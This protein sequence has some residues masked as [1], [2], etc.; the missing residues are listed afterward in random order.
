MSNLPQA[1]VVVVSHQRPAALRRCLLA[2][3]LQDHPDYEVIVVADRA[4]LDAI[5]ELP[6]FDRLKTTRQEETGI[7]AARNRGIALAAGQVVAFIDDDSA[8]EPTWL[9]RLSAPFA[10][11]SVDAAGGFV[12]GRNG[13]SYQWRAK[14]FDETGAHHDL[15]CDDPAISLHRGRPGCAIKTEGTNMALRRSVLMALGGFDPAYTYFKDETDL[16][17]RLAQQG[18]VTA[19]VPRAQVHHGY[20]ASQW[21]RDDRTPLSLYDI[22][23]STAI[24]LRK[25]AESEKTAQLLSTL[26]VQQKHR[27]AEFQRA[28]KL[29]PAQ[30]HDLMLTL[31]HGIAAGQA[32]DLASLQPLDD[33]GTG[34]R[35]LR[36]DPVQ[37]PEFISGRRW[38]LTRLRSRARALDP[39]NRTVSVLVL[40]PSIRRHRVT[41]TDDGY[42]LQTG[43]LWGKSER[44]ESVF[45]MHTFSSRVK[46]ETHRVSGFRS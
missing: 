36:L 37:S 2:L 10:D 13:I 33:Q 22:G 44:T 38:S 27:L 34:F 7:S 4:G 45:R 9:S 26:Q 46:I 25:Y 11:D 18:R 3:N 14:W 35:P 6:F 21:R 20:A 32:R 19:I 29:T 8:A 5:A 40:T 39:F 23:A 43:G 24:F 1:S 28:G 16:N 15:D 30:V 12:R 17:M 31:D 41:F 42:W